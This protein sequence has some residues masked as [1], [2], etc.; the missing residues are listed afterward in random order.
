MSNYKNLADL[1]KVCSVLPIFAVMPAM[2]GTG[3]TLT[4]DG[5]IFEYNEDSDMYTMNSNGSVGSF[6][7]YDASDRFEASIIFVGTG[8]ELSVSDGAIIQGNKAQV[9]GA[10]AITGKT[11]AAT[12]NIGKDVKFLNNTALF[13]GGAIGNYGNTIVANGV[14]FQGNKAQLAPEDNE[15]QIGGGAISLG[16]TSK[17]TI[18]DTD[19]IGNESGYNG[20]AIGT[21][22]ANRTD[23]KQNDNSLATLKISG[24]KF[25]G[26]KANGYK[27]AEG[28][29]VAGNGGAIYNTFYADVVVEDVDFEGNYAAKNG[30]AIYN[31]GTK[32]KNG[33]GGV[34]TINGAEFE[35]N[36][37]YYGGAIFN[38]AGKMDI[39]G[40]ADKRVVF[41]GNKAYVG[42]AF[43]DM[44][45]VGSETFI[46]D[47]LFE[48]NHAGADAG[49]AG[50][51]GK[52]DVENTIFRENTAAISIDGVT[53]DV[54][55]SDG[56]GAILVGGTSDVS[57]TKVQFVGNES[58]ARGGAISARH[59]TGYELDIDTATF[60]TNKSG[61]FG[62]GI[63]N[64]YGGTVNMNN[65]DF[66]SNSAVKAGGA[67][68]NGKDMNYGG[69]TGSM[70]TNHGILNIAGTNTFT[71]NTA[72]EF[73]GAI[74]NDNGGTINMS[75]KNTFAN[76]THGK[77][78]AAN[79]IYNLGTLNITDGTTT[80]GGGIAG[81]GDLVL[82]NGAT[83]NI[84]TA[85]IQQGTVNLDGAIVASA[86]NSKSFGRFAGNVTVG[87]NATLDLTVG[88]VG[89]YDIFAGKTIDVSK[90]TV[91]DTYLVESGTDGIIIT[92]KA[93][94]D[95]ATDTGLT[96][97]AAGMISGLANSTDKNVQK[98]SLAAQQL[99]NSG[100][101]ETVEKEVAKANPDGKPVVQAAATSVQ[102]QVLAVAAGRMSGTAPVVGRAGGDEAQS[103]GFWAQ[104][105]F[106][107]SK[108]ADQFHGYTRGFA[109]GADTMINSAFTL[110]AGFAYNN[111]DIHTVGR[112]HT[113]IDANTLFVYGQYKPTNW[114]VNGTLAYTMAEY[115]EDAKMF[116]NSLVATYDVDSYG[117]QI[118]T[119]YDF[120]SGIT[121]EV[122]ARYLHIAQDS[123]S[124][125]LTSVDS[126]DSDF[127]TGVAGMK[128]AFTIE[129]DWA[130]KLRPEL[131]AAVTYDFVADGDEAVVTMPGVASYKVA[132]E[133][134]KRLGGEFGIGLT[135][136][137][138]GME[139]TAMYDLDLHEDYTSHTGMIKFRG[140]F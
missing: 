2:A 114:F 48:E 97:Q 140:Q 100:D 42:G 1:V 21:R 4:E 22:L 83:L 86:M 59:G 125:G 40:T 84:G 29:Q 107:K 76:N 15:N 65:V 123:Y 63:A 95:I 27:N 122:G 26:N 60:T 113:D 91:G 88:S 47:A 31:D 62:G 112:G 51:Y 106:N 77:Y 55:N 82:E 117:A 89:T 78:A 23:G 115:T 135:A 41:E 80:I 6:S 53:A 14:L 109:L 119:G 9:G 72:G 75:G 99:L 7:G 18:V 5:G 92:T 132:G 105:L 102:N 139:I 70:S 71:G 56:G 36:E 52:V 16:A 38:Y 45:N 96:T 20:G 98:I 94:E 111:S 69:S 118:M 44:Q 50:F 126:M 81:T 46:K 35:E 108:Y 66:V 12:L 68:Y 130:V 17:T 28:K 57:L 10:I 110:G 128:Y 37:A 8:R 74:Y 137:Y 11:P 19:F 61:N 127:L 103:N 58:G 30:G 133:R 134:L 24:G 67:I 121:T 124:N 93:V 129:N 120:A 87:G 101:V 64:V 49:A 33:N 90:V 104:G 39:L 136:L 79:D 54:G 13:D 131:R 73:G 43:S 116:G 85:L 3:I 34:M 25:T 138:N 32:D